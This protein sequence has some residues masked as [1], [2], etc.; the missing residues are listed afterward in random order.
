M[1]NFMALS[2]VFP[3]LFLHCSLFVALVSG[4]K[5]LQGSPPVVIA[6]GGFSGIFP[7]SS[8]PSYNLALKATFPNIT[9]WC[10]VQ[11]TKDGVG[12]CF[13]DIKLDNATDI[14]I[15]Y[16]GKA[17]DYSVNKVPTRG[18]FSLDFNFN[19]LANVSLVQ[20][21]YSRTNKFDGSNYHISTV[22]NVAKLVKSPS[23]GLWLNVQ[24]DTFY[25]HHNLSVEK[26][27][28]SLSNKGVSINYIS[29]PNVD[30][31]RRVRSKSVFKKT[32][33][34][35]R[36]LEQY[37]IEPTTNKTYG[38]LLKNL[39]FIRTFASGILV[40]KGYIWPVDSQLYLQQHTSLV[41]DAHKQGL[42]VFV[43][44]IV[45]D[46]S[47][48]YNFSYDPMAECLS[49]IDN[50]N[51]SVDGILSDFPVTPSA[52]INCFSGLGRNAKKQVETLIISKYGASGDYPACTDLAYKKAK[53][54][55]ADVID[56]PVQISKD[57][58]PFCLSSIDLSKSTTV[59]NTK[60]RNRAAII[61][62]I[63]NGS[64]IYTFSLTWNEIKTLTPSILKPFEK[65]LLFRNPKFKNQGKFV[66]LSDFLSLAKG[67]GILINIEN[68]AYLAEKRGLSVTKAV[69]NT[70]KKSGYDE[71]RS[72]KVMIQSTHKSVL[73]IFKDKSKY[74]RVYKVGEN[75]RDADNK[76]IEDI[77]TFADSVVVQKASVFT[78]SE[79][80]LV[81]STNLVARLQSFKLPVYVETFSNEFVSQAWDYYSDAFVE[82]NSYVVG[83]KV[84]GII[85]DFPKT[86]VRY[87]KNKCLKHGNKAP[88]ISPI[89]PG[90]L[91]KQVTDFY[92]P[93]PS[94]PLPVLHDSNVTEPPLPSVS[95]KL[96]IFSGAR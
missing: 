91:L 35:F 68:A 55:G 86:A 12:I 5:T 52:A 26:F 43:S 87:T 46:V 29:S 72:P 63:Q 76:A 2:S 50:G 8:L 96:P 94:P 15:V 92:L 62:E 79:A 95:K 84:N 1:W 31:L 20:G 77:K 83:A 64:G 39:K 80:F 71:Q 60:F 48:S 10:D 70:L 7:D 32:V 89:Q 54:D 40:P 47:F 17:K 45:N 28:L 58:V 61:P 6:R 56:C 66:T 93:P 74:E 25:K 65:Y 34:I 36:F 22:E 33:T 90:K 37:K 53:S 23:T 24:H 38:A 78:Q 81:N 21:V 49:F 41:S 67:S 9:L 51:F 88:Y 44:D 19:E 4:C 82:I 59:S 42:K 18:W 14:S 13:P 75:I 3:L 57:G 69:L 11:L 73:K 27:L 16:P 30:F 85:T